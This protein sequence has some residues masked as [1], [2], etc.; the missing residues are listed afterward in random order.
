MFINE[1]SKQ[2]LTLGSKLVTRFAIQASHPGLPNSSDKCVFL[3]SSG[4]GGHLSQGRFISCIQGDKGGSIC[5]PAV[6]QVT[7]IQSN[8]YAI[9][10]RFGV[11]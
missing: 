4:A 3:S 9:A 8:Q 6:C 2:S 1:E 11:A 10:G 7:L 5:P